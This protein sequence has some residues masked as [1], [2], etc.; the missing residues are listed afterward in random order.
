M[1]RKGNSKAAAPPARRGTLRL[2]PQSLAATAQVPNTLLPGSSRAGRPGGRWRQPPPRP[3]Q[4]PPPLLTLRRTWATSGTPCVTKQPIPTSGSSPPCSV[5]FWDCAMS[6]EI[7]ELLIGG[8]RERVFADWCRHLLP[9]R[10]RGTQNFGR[11][12]PAGRGCRTA[13]MVDVMELPR[14]RVNASMLAQF[15]DRP[16][17]FVG[18]LEK[19]RAVAALGPL[20]WSRVEGPRDRQGRSLRVERWGGGGQALEQHCAPKCFVLHAWTFRALFSPCSPFWRHF[21]GAE[22]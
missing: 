16:V 5:H 10:R 7:S 18:R 20:L 6:I 19:V 22:S 1:G 12:F 4:A 15:I 11:L 21:Y 3:I 9:H 2:A 13:T 8:V 14:S 17:C